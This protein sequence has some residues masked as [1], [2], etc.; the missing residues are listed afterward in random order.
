[1]SPGSASTIGRLALFLCVAGCDAKSKTDDTG[2]AS[3]VA[4]SSSGVASSRPA[5]PSAAAQS[6]AAPGPSAEAPALDKPNR[7]LEPAAFCERALKLSEA[8][9]GRCT[10]AEQ[11][12]LSAP[13]LDAVKSLR[14]IKKEC[15]VRVRSTKATFE[16]GAASRCSEAA[17]KRG[18]LMTFYRFSE[19]PECR[20]V[21]V[22]TAAEGQPVLYA[23]ECA[24]GLAWV[25]N[26]CA[27]RGAK[28][29]RCSRWASGIL[30][31]PSSHQQ[32]EEGLACLYTRYPYEGDG[33][34][35]HCLEPTPIGGPCR[36]RGRDPRLT[37]LCPASTSC[38][39]GK[40][41]AQAAEGGECM[42]SDDCGP[43]LACELKGAVFGKC[44]SVGPEKCLGSSKP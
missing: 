34:E 29:A 22:G 21:V 16:G 8:N 33:G 1:M 20:G 28:N 2:S 5:P 36:P 11:E 23:E 26:R 40:C 10:F 6:A 30:G 3:S 24:P 27:K 35:S 7:A 38:Y 17:E 4:P 19:I 9:V 25:N 13:E 37:N 41:R 42:A 14:S 18:G 39:Q 44:V 12:N 15:E 31:D 32:C 43:R